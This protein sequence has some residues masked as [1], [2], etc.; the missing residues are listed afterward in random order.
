MKN[1]WFWIKKKLAARFI[2]PYKIIEKKGLVAYKLK[3]PEAMG[4]IFSAFHVSQLKKCLCVP[5]ERTEPQGILIKS[6]LE[7]HEQPVRVLNTK[8]R[9]TR[10]KVVRTYKIQWSHHD[11]GDATCETGEYLQNTYKDFYNKWFVT[12]NLEKRIL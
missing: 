9:V 10:N 11:D 12:Q 1:K 3:L 7:Y 2:G 4:S 5:K 6:D 8:D